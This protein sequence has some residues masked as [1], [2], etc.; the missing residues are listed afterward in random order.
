VS[1]DTAVVSGLSWNSAF[2]NIKDAITDAAGSGE[3]VC[4][5]WV[6][7]GEYNIGSGDTVM[8]SE[9]VLV[10][11]GF[12][13]NEATSCDRDDRSIFDNE[14]VL[15]GCGDATCTDRASHIVEGASN[16]RLDGFIIESGGGADSFGG[17]MYNADVTGLDIKNCIFRNNVVSGSGGAMYNENSS[18]NITNCRFVSN[19]AAVD[20][21]AIFNVAGS[22]PQINESVFIQNSA[23]FRGGAVASGVN[24]GPEIVK[25]AF[26]MN[27]AN[28]TGGAVSLRNTSKSV[29]VL[30]S[31]FA[32]NGPR[33]INGINLRGGAIFGEDA[34]LTVVNGI[35]VANAATTGSGVYL[36]STGESTGVKNK[37]AVRNSVFYRNVSGNFN[38]FST[39]FV[40]ATA[41]GLSVESS[42][43][44]DNVGGI[45]TGYEGSPSLHVLNT[46]AFGNGFAHSI[47][48]SEADIRKMGV[49]AVLEVSYSIANLNGLGNVGDNNQTD[50]EMLF[51]NMEELLFDV[52]QGGVQCVFDD[53]TLKTSVT[54]ASDPPPSF[55]EGSLVGR[56]LMTSHPQNLPGPE[57]EWLVLD[58]LNVAGVWGTVSENTSEILYVWGDIPDVF[59]TLEC[60]NLG[61][62][63]LMPLNEASPAVD[64]ANP[65][66]DPPPPD[67]DLHGISRGDE[68]DIGAVEYVPYN[69]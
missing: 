60:G 14:T 40:D 22:E 20:G 28:E 10:Y 66:S 54:V 35:F 37:A 46:I 39:L 34:S 44:Y 23:A 4:E 67:K 21:G 25:S 11:G 43:I 2:N 24:C 62:L 16:S 32:G 9:G 18:P 27:T 33:D 41:T 42:T 19:T 5:V 1:G 55:G 17:G 69:V 56:I 58:P 29:D 38:L 57:G 47:P 30:D 13:G 53:K 63:D 64:S 68:P 3:D 65:S 61:I 31:W 48:N 12:V 59:S 45:V 7:Q 49:D 51:R 50:V 15:H 52:N 6:A 26:I 36:D 8:L